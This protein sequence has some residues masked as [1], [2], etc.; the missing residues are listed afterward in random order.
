MPVAPRSLSSVIS[1][2]TLRA[3]VRSIAVR[4]SAKSKVAMLAAAA[5]SP[6]LARAIAADYPFTFCPKEGCVGPIA[7]PGDCLIDLEGAV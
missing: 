5:K 2:T 4:R 3:A 6:L 1:V 7:Q